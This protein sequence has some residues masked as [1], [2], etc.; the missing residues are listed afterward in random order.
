MDVAP[1]PVWPAGVYSSVRPVE[2]ERE[3][4]VSMRSVKSG[5][6]REQLEARITPEQKAL[7]QRAADLTGRSPRISW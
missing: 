3:L 4:E 6:K 5:G 7:F 2:P 1:G